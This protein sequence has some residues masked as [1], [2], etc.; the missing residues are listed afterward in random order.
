MCGNYHSLKLLCQ[1]K[2]IQNGYFFTFSSNQSKKLCVP[3]SG[4]SDCCL[5][6]APLKYH[7]QALPDLLLKGKATFKAHFKYSK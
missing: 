2:A 3:I 5:M 4:R 1:G 6:H 7:P